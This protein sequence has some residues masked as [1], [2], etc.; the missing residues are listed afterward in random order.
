MVRNYEEWRK[1]EPGGWEL[2]AQGIRMIEM[3]IGFE[4]L[5][6]CH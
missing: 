3:R 1:G 6:M 5:N 2:A 4:V